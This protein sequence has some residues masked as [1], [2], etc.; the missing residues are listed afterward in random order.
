M[1]DTLET[2][3]ARY[4]QRRLTKPAAV[5]VALFNTGQATGAGCA[6]SEQSKDRV[7]C[8]FHER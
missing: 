1:A 2:E 5:S 3:V 4:L 7:G 6:S 8:K